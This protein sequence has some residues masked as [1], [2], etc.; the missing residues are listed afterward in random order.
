VH[1][2]EVFSGFLSALI[3]NIDQKLVLFCGAIK[4][5][6]PYITVR[7]ILYFI[8][9]VLLVYFYAMALKVSYTASVA[10]PFNTGQPCAILRASSI[11]LALI[12]V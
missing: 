12:T 10:P 4:I 7:R 5:N 9:L 2:G 1:I 3:Y 6:P 11:E 8:V